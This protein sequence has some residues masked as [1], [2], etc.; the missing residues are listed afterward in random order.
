MF[1]TIFMLTKSTV[2]VLSLRQ[3]YRPLKKGALCSFTVLIGGV[4]TDT[5]SGCLEL[6]VFSM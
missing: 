5:D 2:R 4:P 3:M 6:E 1:K